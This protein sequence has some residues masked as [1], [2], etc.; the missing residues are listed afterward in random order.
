MKKAIQFLA[1]L[2]IGILLTSCSKQNKSN[3]KHLDN[4]ISK[5]EVI[6]FHSTHRCMTCKAI[7]ANTKYTLDTYFSKELKED[8]VTFQVINVDEKANEKIAEKFEAS[9]TSL[10]LNVIK[11]GKETQINLTDFA[12]MEGNNKDLFSKELKAKIEAELKTL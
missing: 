8:K 10:I 1:V 6:D 7:E 4:S 5:I 2:T 11:N 12:F 9:G 3:V